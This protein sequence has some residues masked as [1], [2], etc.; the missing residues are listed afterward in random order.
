M[1][2]EDHF[3]RLAERLRAEVPG[4]IVDVYAS[5]LNEVEEQLA[6][7]ELFDGL[8]AA[9]ARIS[10]ESAQQLWQLARSW[11]ITRFTEAEVNALAGR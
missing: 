1:S 10:V 7:E 8:E 5:Y 11:G 3:R 6:L 4:E 9:G 2:T